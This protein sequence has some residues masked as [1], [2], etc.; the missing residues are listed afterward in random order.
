MQTGRGM[1]TKTAKVSQLTPASIYQL[2]VTLKWSEP[3]IWRRLQV[4]GDTWL[5]ELHYILQI[6]MGWEDAHLHAFVIGGADYGDP[7]TSA[8]DEFEARLGEVAGEGDAFIYEY[9]FGDGWAHELVIEQ[10]LAPEAGAH[11][12]RCLAGE[13]AC[14]PEDS[15]GIP[16]YEHKL[17]VLAD[18]EDEGYEELR[19][20]LG[21]EFDP[22]AFDLAAANAGLES[23]ATGLADDD[24]E[25][26]LPAYD[27]A[28][29]ASLDEATLI[30]RL[31]RDGDRAPRNLIDACAERGDAMVLALQRLLHSP[32]FD[33]SNDDDDWWMSLHAAMIAGLIPSESAGTLLIELMGRLEAVDDYAM[34]DWLAGYWPALFANKPLS[35]EVP[36]RALAES[37]EH[38]DFVRTQAADAVVRLACREGDEQREAAIDWVAGLAGDQTQALD[39]R[40]NFCFTLLDFPRDRHRPLLEELA[41][42]QSGLGRD[43]DKH[44]IE[45]VYDAGRDQPEWERFAD[46]WKFYDPAEIENRQRRWAKEDAAG[47]QSSD[48]LFGGP[49]DRRPLYALPEPYVRQEPKVGRN[50]PCPCGSGKKY[51]KCCLGKG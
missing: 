4:R 30:E 41:R 16:G 12:P 50:D 8:H 37:G 3:P 42:L 19:D 18:P 6:A 39:S 38:D 28:E 11:Y 44:N 34:T 27:D 46:P 21:E 25:R 40:T 2:K 33:A 26:L 24:A 35:I 48:D 13:R 17:A 15:G 1:T 47:D 20:W 14:P 31:R 32:A 22:E 9:D 36:L 7:D 5:G 51:K 29:L 45:Q 23:F 43:F 10:I 49:Y